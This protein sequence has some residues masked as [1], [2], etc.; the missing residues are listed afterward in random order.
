MPFLL[1]HASAMNI[2]LE[3]DFPGDAMDLKVINS[4]S[5]WSFSYWAIFLFWNRWVT[6]LL[7]SSSHMPWR[8][9]C[10]HLAACI[11]S[12]TRAVMMVQFVSYGFKEPLGTEAAKRKGKG[13]LQD[14]FLGVL[15]F[16]GTFFVSSLWTAARVLSSALRQSQWYLHHPR[17]CLPQAF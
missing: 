14:L 3:V 13:R 15:T 11:G 12:K 1:E 10:S 4:W 8:L 9:S 7:H 5:F 6:P 16:S 2:Y 17:A